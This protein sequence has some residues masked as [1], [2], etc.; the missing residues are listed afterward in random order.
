MQ[1]KH[2]AETGFTHSESQERFGVNYRTLKVAAF[3]SRMGKHTSGP[4]SVIAELA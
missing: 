4:V 3:S 1:R 2:R